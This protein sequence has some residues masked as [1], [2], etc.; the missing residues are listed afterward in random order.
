MASR[1][2]W[3]YSL[4]TLLDICQV[5]KHSGNSMTTTFHVVFVMKIIEVSIILLTNFIAQNLN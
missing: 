4:S 2:I 1:S 3:K 5:H